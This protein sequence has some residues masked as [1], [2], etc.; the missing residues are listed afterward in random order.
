MDCRAPHHKESGGDK[1]L[2][3]LK[4]FLCLLWNGL[5]S[6][7]A[8]VACILYALLY[9]LLL[10]CLFAVE[11][12]IYCVNACKQSPLNE[13]GVPGTCLCLCWVVVLQELLDSPFRSD[14][15]ISSCS[16]LT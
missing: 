15:R 13:E 16:A 3:Y 10:L 12:V 4:T 11:S 14:E 9:L 8:A 1:A 6:V 5:V 2:R 7:L